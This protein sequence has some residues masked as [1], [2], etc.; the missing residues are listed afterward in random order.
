MKKLAIGVV[1][2][3]AASFATIRSGL[4]SAKTPASA[5]TER[6]AHDILGDAIANQKRGVQVEGS[7]VVTRLLEDDNVG[8]R[9][10]RFIV[11]LDTGDTLLIAHNIDLAKRIERLEKG[12]RVEFRG[13]YEWN[14]QGGVIHW[15]HHDPAGRHPGGWLKHDGQTFQ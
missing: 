15:T 5:P 3:A 9:H 11:R 1:I 6:V 12:D 2:L 14:S 4:I 13:E 7:G 10:Q 8:S